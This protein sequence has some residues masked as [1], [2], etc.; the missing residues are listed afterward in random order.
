MKK[1]NVTIILPTYNGGKYIKRAIESI[2]HQTFFNW[3]LLI[4]DDGSKD[5]TEEVVKKYLDKDSR[6]VYLKNEVNLGIQKTL[7]KGLQSSNGEFIARIDDDDEWPDENKLKKQV[8]FLENNRDYVLVGTGVIVV[9]ED[10]QELFRYL[11]PETDK[12]IRNKILSKNCFV[13]SSVV[14]KKNTALNF[15][16]Y[17]ESKDTRHI[18]DYDLWLKLGNVGKLA[19]LATFAVKFTLRDG[20]ISSINKKEQFKKNTILIKKFKND[21]PNYF[22]ALIRSYLRKFIYGLIINSPF[23]FYLSKIIKIYKNN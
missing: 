18:E 13:H 12:E 14:F 11:M 17:N 2:L 5:N 10:G 6:I 16:G 4:I 15:K 19:N 23:K 3:E 7:N 21:Y 8:E 22:L 9:G 1:I 20:S